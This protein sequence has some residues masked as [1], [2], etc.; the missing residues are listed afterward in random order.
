MSY[1]YDGRIEG[2]RH[3]VRVLQKRLQRF[4]EEVERSAELFDKTGGRVTR[5]RLLDE[6]A[7]VVSILAPMENALNGFGGGDVE[8]STILRAEVKRL[9]ALKAPVAERK[10]APARKAARTRRA[11]PMTF[12]TRTG[13]TLRLVVNDASLPPIVPSTPSD[14]AAA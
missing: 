10:G 2:A 14:G 9:Q 7:F 5:R 13:Q 1:P 8:P 6:A 3:F 4:T 11:K 12:Q